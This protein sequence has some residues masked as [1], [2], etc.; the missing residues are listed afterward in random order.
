MVMIDS[1]LEWNEKRLI[2]I[3]LVFNILYGV[4]QKNSNKDGQPFWISRET[5]HQI[6]VNFR[7][8]GGKGGFGAQIRAGKKISGKRRKAAVESSR[9]L[10]GKRLRTV[11]EAQMIAEYEA[12][13]PALERKK[14]ADLIEKLQ[15]EIQIPFKKKKA[16]DPVYLSTVRNAVD[17]VE[18]AIYEA[19]CSESDGSDPDDIEL[20]DSRPECNESQNQS[21]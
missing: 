20:H 14:K 16:T 3:D 8:P 10:D 6:R 11:K 4:F 2:I 12:K 15:K 9:N 21:T 19:L 7:L 18:S 17:G 5:G 1:S 13:W